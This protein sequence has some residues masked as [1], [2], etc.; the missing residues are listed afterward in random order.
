MHRCRINPFIISI[1]RHSARKNAIFCLICIN[2]DAERQDPGET[3]RATMR[4]RCS[5]TRSRYRVFYNASAVG[6]TSQT[7]MMIGSRDGGGAG[8]SWFSICIGRIGGVTQ[9]EQIIFNKLQ[10]RKCMFLPAT[11]SVAFDSVRFARLTLPY[12]VV[13][14]GTIGIV[15]KIHHQWA[16]RS[17]QRCSPANGFDPQLWINYHLQNNKWFANDLQAVLL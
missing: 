4:L 15:K 3:R 6:C 17:M 1:Q 11:T 2:V 10:V 12:S 14:P 8:W 13:R 5:F 7:H 16:F 9:L